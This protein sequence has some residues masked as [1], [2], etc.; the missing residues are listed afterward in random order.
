MNEQKIVTKPEKSVKSPEPKLTQ[1]K[2]L[3]FSK[4]GGMKKPDLSKKYDIL[5]KK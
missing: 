3:D 4:R 5:M 2:P 1:K